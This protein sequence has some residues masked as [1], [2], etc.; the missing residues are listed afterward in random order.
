MDKTNENKISKEK[1]KSSELRLNLS[2]SESTNESNK[3][4][5]VSSSP[6]VGRNNNHVDGTGTDD[7]GGK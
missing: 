5:V 6:S 1:E 7:E 2:N 4:R 3:R